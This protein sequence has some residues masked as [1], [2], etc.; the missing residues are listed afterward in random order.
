MFQVDLESS[1]GVLDKG[2]DGVFEEGE[3]GELG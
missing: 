2:R 3:Y 1:L